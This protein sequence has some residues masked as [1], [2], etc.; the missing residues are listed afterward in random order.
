MK[1][2]LLVALIL[3]SVTTVIPESAEA[4]LA[5]Q[6]QDGVRVRV[7]RNNGKAVVGFINA[8]THDSISIIKPRRG[9]MPQS[10]SLG[11]ISHVDVS[12]GRSRARGAMIKGA[13]GLG[14]GAVAGAF[15][16]AA[17]YTEGSSCEPGPNNWCL[18]DCFIICSRTEAGAFG[19]VLGGSAGLL[20][21]TII[22]IATGWEQWQSVPA[23]I[24]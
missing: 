12:R 21:G 4:Q 17:T 3:T 11:D 9:A 10:F 1:P 24:R 2:V 7:V 19:G 23:R 8:R 6:L 18:F 13:I 20:V 5:T 22:G 15:A 16:G 14:I